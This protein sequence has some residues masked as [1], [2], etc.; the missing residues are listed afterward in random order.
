MGDGYYYFHLK[1][2]DDGINT[3]LVPLLPNPIYNVS[4]FLG[5]EQFGCTGRAL[6]H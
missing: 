3:E 6:T 2:D 1:G 4:E 5:Y